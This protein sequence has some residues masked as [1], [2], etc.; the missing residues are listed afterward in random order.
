MASGLGERGWG[1]LGLG[2]IYSKWDVSGTL[3][4][5]DE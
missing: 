1:C 4:E 3:N 2:Y 5:I